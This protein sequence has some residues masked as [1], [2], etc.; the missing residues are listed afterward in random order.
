MHIHGAHNSQF[1]ALVPTESAQQAGAARKAAA[2]VRRRL[3]SF[4]AASETGA[5][6]RVAAYMPGERGQDPPQGEDAF[7]KMLVSIHS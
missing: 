5:I 4:A 7:R 6:S 3:S 2:E 1:A